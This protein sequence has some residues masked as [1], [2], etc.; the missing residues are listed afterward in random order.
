MKCIFIIT[1]IYEVSFA[2]IPTE[3]QG[4]PSQL[5]IEGGGLEPTNFPIKSCSLSFAKHANNIYVLTLNLMASFLNKNPLKLL[6]KLD[7]STL[8][9]CHLNGLG[10]PPSICWF[11]STMT[12]ITAFVVFT[13][14]RCTSPH[15]HPPLSFIIGLNCVPMPNRTLDAKVFICAISNMELPLSHPRF[16]SFSSLHLESRSQFRSRKLLSNHHGHPS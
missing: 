14:C 3:C 15:I 16:H 9:Q 12:S 2:H 11:A 4:A 6:S 7:G 5:L 1:I 10:S 8:P 13:S